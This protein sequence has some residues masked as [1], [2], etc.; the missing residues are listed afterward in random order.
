LIFQTLVLPELRTRNEITFEF[1]YIGYATSNDAPGDPG[2]SA[3][4]HNI[5]G[6]LYEYDGLRR[7][8][9]LLKLDQSNAEPE[10][11]KSLGEMK[12]VIYFRT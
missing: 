7:N 9:A 12:Y 1:G 8:E 2:H 5:D 4:I 3:A 11:H 10:P 6:E